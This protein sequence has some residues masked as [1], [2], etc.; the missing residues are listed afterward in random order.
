MNRTYP[1]NLGFI[2]AKNL[3]KFY[4]VPYEGYMGWYQIKYY[5]KIDN[6]RIMFVL[7]NIENYVVSIGTE[8]IAFT[9]KN[10]KTP[11]IFC[12]EICRRKQMRKL[13]GCLKSVCSYFNK[14]LHDEEFYILSKENAEEKDDDDICVIM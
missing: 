4:F 3:K 1:F 7:D 10:T 2:F 9:H 14:R 8:M 5:K 13:H 12:I 11:M 6:H